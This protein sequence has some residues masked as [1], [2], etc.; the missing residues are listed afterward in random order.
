MQYRTQIA[1]HR[2]EAARLQLT[3]RLL[4]HDLPRQKQRAV[5]ADVAS[6]HGNPVIEMVYNARKQ[7][8]LSET[9]PMRQF[10]P[11]A[12]QRRRGV[13]DDVEIG[14]VLG[15]RRRNP[16]EETCAIT[17]SGECVHRCQGDGLGCSTVDGR[18]QSAPGGKGSDR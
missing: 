14:E 12:Y 16:V 4:I 18:Q 5:N 15:T 9:S 13:E 6:S 2:L 11:A 17:V 10:S 7:Q 1:D 8:A 3:L